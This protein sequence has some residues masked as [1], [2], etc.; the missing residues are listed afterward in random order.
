MNLNI[1]LTKI[2]SCI[3]KV[4]ISCMMLFQ[5]SYL[6]A[7]HT[8][9][10][11]DRDILYLTS[12]GK[13]NPVQANMDI[14][15]YTLVLDVDMINRS[16]S[17]YT[18]VSMNLTQKSD[19]ILLDLI[20]LYK[21]SKIT[22]NGKSTSFIHHDDKLFITSPAGFEMG[23]KKVTIYYSGIPPVA[24]RPPWD[25]GF[26]WSKDSNGNDW[27]S[28]NIQGEG[29]KMFFPCKDHPSDEPNEG[30]DLNNNNI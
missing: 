24:I 7:Q 22:V 25:G 3:I 1:Q 9:N 30:A 23:N 19:S 20:H 6:I 29:G 11:N 27:M 13:L 15:H 14:R 12:G 17:G 2:K 28:I 8:D 21:V 5:A 18:E 16:I 10:I 26:T 4:S